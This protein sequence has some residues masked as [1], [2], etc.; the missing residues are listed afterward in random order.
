MSLSFK[1]KA[2]VCLLM[3]FEATEDEACSAGEVKCMCGGGG[4]VGEG[5]RIHSSM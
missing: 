4:V 2:V 5:L 1:R 3:C